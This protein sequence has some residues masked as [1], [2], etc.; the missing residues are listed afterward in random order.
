[1]ARLAALGSLA[2]GNHTWRRGATTAHLQLT[3]VL[4]QG[5]AWP[6][7][8]R[9]PRGQNRAPVICSRAPSCGSAEILCRPNPIEGAL[10]S[11]STACAT[12]RPAQTL[13][14]KQPARL[15]PVVVAEHGVCWSDVKASPSGSRDWRALVPDSQSLRRPLPLRLPRCYTAVTSPETA[16]AAALSGNTVFARA[17]S[18]RRR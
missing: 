15:R 7:Q 13:N 1:M 2:T 12:P 10:P 14:E 8:P 5:E 16:R 6:H 11:S 3:S 17:A 18:G 9:R 4:S